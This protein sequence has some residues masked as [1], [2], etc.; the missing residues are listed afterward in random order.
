MRQEAKKYRHAYWPGTTPAYE[1][2]PLGG[3]VRQIWRARPS[4]IEGQLISRVMLWS[5]GSEADYH[6]GQFHYGFDTVA[7]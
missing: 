1:K 4:K 3:H 7:R 5:P 2:P 6:E